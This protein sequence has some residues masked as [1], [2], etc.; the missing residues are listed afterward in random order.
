MKHRFLR[1]FMIIALCA[2][3][4]AVSALAVPAAPGSG[5]EGADAACRSHSGR[6]ITL[7]EI[8][9][10]LVAGLIAMI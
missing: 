6:L 2:A 3:L 9:A 4:L 7:D 1:H 8:P 10:A 5:R